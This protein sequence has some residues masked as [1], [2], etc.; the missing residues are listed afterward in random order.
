MPTF[1]T[2]TSSAS[3]TKSWNRVKDFNRVASPIEAVMTST[4]TL[5]SAIASWPQ[6]PQQPPG[7]QASSGS[8]VSSSGGKGRQP[9]RP[10]SKLNEEY[11]ISSPVF[12]EFEPSTI[13][14]HSMLRPNYSQ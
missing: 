2:T 3:R 1:S 9:P 4:T 10:T 13:R 6:Q 7:G 5:A 11:V 8:S 14:P 12:Y